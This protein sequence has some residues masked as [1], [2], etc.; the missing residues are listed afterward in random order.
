MPIHLSHDK[1]GS[2]YQWGN[3]KKY[4]FKTQKGQLMALEKCKKQ[5]AAIYS[6]GYKKS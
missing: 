3:Q 6:T 4:Y 1:K 5:E 2:Y